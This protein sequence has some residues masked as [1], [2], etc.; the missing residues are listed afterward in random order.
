MTEL[1]EL[2]STTV[3]HTSATSV[4]VMSEELV[5]SKSLGNVCLFV[6]FCFVLSG[7]LMELLTDALL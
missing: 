3:E 1:T 6:S 2:E 5:F 4:T 7:S